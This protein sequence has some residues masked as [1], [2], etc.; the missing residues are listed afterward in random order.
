MLLDAF[1]N[2]PGFYILENTHPPGGGGV[3][4][5]QLMSF[6]GKNMKEGREKVGKCKRKG[7]RGKEKEKMD[8]KG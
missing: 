5:Y 8:V 1:G 3:E 7:R 2:L 4:K 6:R